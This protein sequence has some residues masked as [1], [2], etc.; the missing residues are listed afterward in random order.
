MLYGEYT[1][2]FHGLT[3]LVLSS[4]H[5]APIIISVAE[6][7]SGVVPRSRR[8]ANGPS[9]A[10]GGFI[11]RRLAAHSRISPTP[12]SWF[13]RPLL[14]ARPRRARAP[15]PGTVCAQGIDQKPKERSGTH[16]GDGD[17]QI[18]LHGSILLSAIP[19][20][21]LTQPGHAGSGISPGVRAAASDRPR[22]RVGDSYA[23]TRLPT[24]RGDVVTCAAHC[25]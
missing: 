19:S 17:D 24:V 3:P 14:V 5:P 23:A 22:M 2:H 4:Q 9:S 12:S 6:E 10:S 7:G 1:Q 11:L 18:R 16:D 25:G 13:R 20:A 15:A 21:R 8:G